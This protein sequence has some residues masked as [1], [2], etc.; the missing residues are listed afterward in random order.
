MKHE[1]PT[2][3]AQPRQRTGSRYARRLRQAGRLPAVIYGHKVEPV[4]VSV[5]EKEIL[6]FIRHGAHVMKL[7]IENGKTETCLVKDLQFGYLGDDV[8]HVDFARVNLQEQVTV[9]VHLAYVGTPEE[10]HHA[11]AILRHDHTEL[12]VTC[13][14]SEIP[15]EI[16]VDLSK[17]KG[18]H[19]LAGAVE[20]PS[21]V[22][23]AED[24]E[25]MIASITYVKRQAEVGEEAE[26]EAEP[27][28]PEVI[29][30]ARAEDEG[31]APE[32]PEPADSETE[33]S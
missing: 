1:T 17:M 31:G 28:E 30:E 16:K 5:D 23:L 21:H 6:H 3:T 29:T 25:T 7:A 10:A 9:N 19:L 2:L 20:L 13:K 24:P 11:G 4:S 15:E 27:G 26:V 18:M 8:I 32:K 33:S 22:A 12:A 14:V